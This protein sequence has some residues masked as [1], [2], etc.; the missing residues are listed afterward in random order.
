MN[1]G[2]KQNN[3]TKGHDVFLKKSM[4]YPEIACEFFKS[5][6]PEEVLKIIDLNT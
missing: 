5:Y 6:L 3:Y 1:K 2:N 4:S